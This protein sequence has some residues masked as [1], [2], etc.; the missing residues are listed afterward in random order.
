M[1]PR[2]EGYSRSERHSAH[3]RLD[4]DTEYVLR[5]LLDTQGRGWGPTGYGP[6]TSRT[7]RLLE[8]GLV[9]TRATDG[10]WHAR[11]TDAGVRAAERVTVR[12]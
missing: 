12:R 5:E 2:H 1:T 6:P 11:L 7:R 9:E 4:R 3:E 8:G 10:G